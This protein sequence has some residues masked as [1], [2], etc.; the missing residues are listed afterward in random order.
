MLAKILE[1]KR[2]EVEISKQERPLSTLENEVTAASHEFYEAIER[3]QW[4]LI[5]ECKKASPLK[6][7]LS[8]CDIATLARVY[9]ENGA[10]ALSVLTDLHF[11]GTLADIQEAR[12]ACKL[13][14]LRKDFIVD[15]YQIVEAR[16]AGAHAI[17]LIA[18]S[19]TDQQITDYLAKA[20][21]LGMDCLVEVHDREELDRVQLTSAK[22]IGI[23]NRDLKTFQTSVEKTFELLPFCLPGRMIISE[24]GIQSAEDAI[25]LKTAGV[26]GILVGES[27]VTAED[28]GQKVRELS[29]TQVGG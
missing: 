17:L 4:V 2:Q 28:I 19:L 11:S 24:S 7:P 10:T 1:K 16:A 15:E 20:D 27:L 18:S 12:Q 8:S 13:P 14:V 23:N 25:R 9:G 21:E 5:A 26:R 29:L 22:I 3:A 6:G